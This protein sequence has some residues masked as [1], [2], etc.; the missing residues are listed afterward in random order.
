MISTLRVSICNILGI[1]SHI[2]K[3]APEVLS[4]ISSCNKV[5]RLKGFVTL[6]NSFYKCEKHP[7]KPQQTSHHW[8]GWHSFSRSWLITGN[9]EWIDL[10]KSKFTPRTWVKGSWSI[11]L[12]DTRIKWTF[13]IVKNRELLPLYVCFLSFL[14]VFAQAILST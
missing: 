5:Q 8:L 6:W 7:Q 9:G 2:W 11:G 4:I 12:P 10:N 14:E 3:M 13:E 1:P